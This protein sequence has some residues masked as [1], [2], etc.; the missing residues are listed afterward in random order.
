MP[1]TNIEMI[2]LTIGEYTFTFQDSVA[3]ALCTALQTALAGKEAS[4]NKVTVW[5]TTPDD[6]HYPSEKLVRESL[7]A[8]LPNTPYAVIDSSSTSTV[9]TATVNG[10]AELS[11]GLFVYLKNNNVASASGC[12]LNVNNLGAKPIY[13][14]TTGAA[15]TTHLS[16]NYTYLFIYNESR[17]T[18]GCWDLLVGYDSNSTY[19]NASLGCGCG[20]CETA[21]A[22][23]AKAVTLSS[24]SLATGGIVAVRFVHG[25]PAS[26][27]LNINSKGAKSIVYRG[28][29]IESGVIGAGD[30]ATFIYNG[31][32]Y[33]LLAID[34]SA[35]V[36]TK[37]SEFVDDLGNNPS[38]T[39]S[40]YLTS[41]QDISGKADKVSNPTNGNFASLDSNG[42]IADSGHKH[43]D[44]ITSHQDISGKADKVSNPTNGNFASLDSNGNI[45]DS[46]HKHSDY[47]TSHQDISGK[48]DKVS[49][50][51]NDDLASLDAN[52]NLKDSG[53][54]KSG[55]RDAIDNTHR[56]TNKT[57]LDLIP[58]TL[59]EIGEALVI[60]DEGTGLKFGSIQGSGG[61]TNHNFTHSANQTVNTSIT[62]TYNA[63]TRGSRMVSTA[64]DLSVAFVVNSGSDH[65]L[66]VRNTGTSDIDVVINSVTYNNTAINNVYSPDGGITIKA[67]FVAEIG[68]LCNADGAFVTSRNDLIL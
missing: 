20:T 4:A 27:T 42:N 55:V 54:P 30:V 36:K 53:L 13:L 34:R 63:N 50:S 24:Y 32:N 60:D 46:G 28:T 56:H 16:K 25:V 8:K 15:I 11:D 21:E 40:Q 3:R 66:W 58:D 12:T 51:T 14:S 26:A 47:I 6:D 64:A 23:V 44:Y 7:D 39:H 57:I 2:D 45:A 59:G 33:I 62:V 61:V 1:D 5:Q 43:S 68:I 48:A 38:H 17:I 10:V 22:T 37:L 19:S 18:G 29:A 31:A 41:H 65:Y 67:G 49:N 52:G 9:K 35:A